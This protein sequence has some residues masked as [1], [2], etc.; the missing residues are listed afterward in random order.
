M[1]GAE[2]FSSGAKVFC[3]PTKSFCPCGITDKSR[4]GQKILMY[5]KLLR[6]VLASA[7]FA[8]LKA[9]FI[10]GRNI[11][12]RISTRVE[13]FCLEYFIKGI[14][15]GRHMPLLI[16]FIRG[17]CSYPSRCTRIYCLSSP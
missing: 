14:F 2:I 17:V 8:L 12:F 7:P 3:S 4:G 10:G 11:I 15:R 9:L 1:G 6:H 13:L 5:L 16:G